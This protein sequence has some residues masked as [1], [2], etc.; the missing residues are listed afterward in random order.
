MLIKPTTMYAQVAV[1]VHDVR[2]GKCLEPAPWDFAAAYV[3]LLE[4]KTH[5]QV[6]NAIY[7]QLVRKRVPKNGYLGRYLFTE[8]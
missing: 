4:D 2:T 1:K 8:A 7:E 3:A 5:R 6:A